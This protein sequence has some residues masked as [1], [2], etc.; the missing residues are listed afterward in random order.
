VLASNSPAH[1]IAMYAISWAGAV[2][3]PL[4]TRLSPAE[5]SRIMTES[6]TKALFSDAANH[7]AAES[8]LVAEQVV[9]IAMDKGAVG[10]QSWAEVCAHDPIEATR[11]ELSD[12]AAIYYTGG[13]TGA[14]KGV[15][16][17]YGTLL[18]QAMN[19]S[20]ELEI[21]PDAIV[22]HAPPLF[23][24]A[25]AGTAQASVLAGATQI[26]APA[27]EPAEML[28]SIR[29][30]KAT[31]AVAVPTML[32]VLVEMDGVREAFA[33]LRRIVYGTSSITESLLRK[34][35]AV[36]PQT[37]LSQ[38]YGQTE[39]AGPCLF[40][41]PEDHLLEG[42][43][44]SRLATAGRPDR[45]SEVKLVDTDGKPVAPGTPGEIVIRGPS[46]M[47]GYWKNET[48]TN[49]ALR[50]GWLHTGDVGVE[51]EDGYVRVVDRIKDMIITG[52][53]NVFCAEV[54]NVIMTLPE[55]K[56]CAVI[57]VPDEKWGE[58]V[59]AIIGV[60]PDSSLTREA[61]IEHCRHSIAGYKCPKSVEFTMTP[62]PLSAVGKVRKDLL[63]KQYLEQTKG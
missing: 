7:L 32:A 44:Q 12:L 62:L 33:S 45:F 16:L 38:I 56:F 8:L 13:T 5:M 60:G 40:L 35:I 25:G 48:A 4:N 31:H 23:H 55:A 19:L 39:C 49:D 15:M 9:S 37:G 20:S 42:E 10:S 11:S 50:N 17:S 43:K 52:G 41:P 30:N 61:V 28:A 6:G 14:P 59:H 2:L 24:L 3:V 1:A 53:E 34:V 63:R 29:D 51:D 58:N 18:V 54:E 46:V 47:M 22:Q 57:G 36:A 26:F 21:G 27:F